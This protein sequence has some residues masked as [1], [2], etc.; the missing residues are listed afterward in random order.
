[1]IAVIEGGDRR[2]I[3]RLGIQFRVQDHQATVNAL[4]QAGFTAETSALTSA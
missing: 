3:V 2:E 4:R 1:V